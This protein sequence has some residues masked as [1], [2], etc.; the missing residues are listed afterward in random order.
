MLLKIL[1]IMS[2]CFLL[3]AYQHRLIPTLEIIP[4]NIIPNMTEQ[5]FIETINDVASIYKPIASQFV[6]PKPHAYNVVLYVTPEWRD[7]TINAFADQNNAFWYVWIKGGIGK[8]PAIT[9]LGLIAITCHEI[10]HHLGGYPKKDRWPW[11]SAEAQAD[12]FAAHVCM[13]KVFATYSK[14]YIVRETWKYCDGLSEQDAAICNLTLSAAQENANL[15]GMYWK[16]KMTPSYDTPDATVATYTNTGYPNPQCRLDSYRYGAFC[17]KPWDDYS[18][19]VDR[20]DYSCDRPAC[21]Y[22]E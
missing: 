18:H 6:T 8:H 7:N 19:N 20:S 13:R 3:S 16:P 11:A 22:R 12:Y 1:F 14:K 10:G 9:R 17:W 2:H 5:D 15:L 21:W 4:N